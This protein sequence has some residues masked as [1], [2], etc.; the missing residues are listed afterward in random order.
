MAAVIPVPPDWP[1]SPPTVVGAADD[2][3]RTVGA[4]TVEFGGGRATVLGQRQRLIAVN[5][6]Q[7]VSGLGRGGGDEGREFCEQPGDVTPAL[8]QHVGVGIDRHQE[9]VLVGIDEGG[10]H[11]TPVQRNSSVPGELEPERRRGAG[12]GDHAVV[13]RDRRKRAVNRGGS[14]IGT[15]CRMNEPQLSPP[16]PDTSLPL[17][18]KKIRARCLKRTV[19]GIT[20]GRD[21]PSRTDFKRSTSHV[22]HPHFRFTPH[23]ASPLAHRPLAAAA[24]IAA[25]GLVRWPGGRRGNGT[26][27]AHTTVS[28]TGAGAF[29]DREAGT[30]TRLAAAPAKR[31][32][33]VANALI[34]G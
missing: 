16:A 31:G 7:G 17:V 20:T 4:D 18:G 5:L 23:P 12:S 26:S 21:G 33:P 32:S 6:S 29:L 8:V 24:G 13:D 34:R 1:S 30:G 2:V 9:G 15:P 27:A 22:Q 14:G 3:Q 28:R 11:R 25:V 19:S 10:H